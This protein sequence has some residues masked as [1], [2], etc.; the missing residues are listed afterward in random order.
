MG[1]ISNLINYRNQK[2]QQA[3]ERAWAEEERAYNRQLQQQIFQREDTAVQRRVADLEAAGLNPNLASG[4]GAGAGSVVGGTSASTS[5]VQMGDMNLLGSLQGIASIADTMSQI[6]AR[7][8]LLPGQMEGIAID[9]ANKVRTGQGIDVDNRRKEHDFKFY[10]DSGL[11]TTMSPEYAIMGALTVNFLKSV[12]LLPEDF[13][14]M[15]PSTW[16]NDNSGEGNDGTTPR[17]EYVSKVR[18]EGT[19]EGLD[20]YGNEVWRLPS[21]SRAHIK[22]TSSTLDGN[23]WAY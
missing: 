13:D 20:G 3:Y 4:Q 2:E 18:R 9:N 16:Y 7:N 19:Y 5:G 21:G 10:E 17:N 22:S 1:V 23:P 12:G 8:S 15:D 6:S 11:P 14:M